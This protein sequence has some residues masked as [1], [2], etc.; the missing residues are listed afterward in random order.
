MKFQ[1][2]ALK[3]AW[4]IEPERLEDD[5]GFF[6][7][8]FCERELGD[9]GLETRYVQHSIS[10]NRRKGTLRG[11]HYQAPPHEETKIVRCTAGAIYDVI[12]DLRRSSPTFRKW[13]ATELTAENRRMLYVPKGFAHGFQVLAEQSEVCYQISAFYQP[14]AARGIRWNDEDLDIHW[15][16]TAGVVSDRDAALPRLRDSEFGAYVGRGT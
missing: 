2:L 9:A 14:E 16:L 11:L 1:E 12:V 6:A 5:R 13:T 10:L 8:T 4:L 15:P 7:R 3:G